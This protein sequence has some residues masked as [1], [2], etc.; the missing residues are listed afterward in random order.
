V[1]SRRRS[2][3]Y[4]GALPATFTYNGSYSTNNNTSGA[5]TMSATVSVG[6]EFA[7]RVVALVFIWVSD[8]DASCVV[9][10]VSIG[11]V[12]CTIA[13]QGNT[14]RA[15]TTRVGVC[16]ALARLPT[17]T[18]ATYSVTFS[19]NHAN[20]IRMTTYSIANL[21]S[22]V[23]TDIN[24]DSVAAASGSSP[25]NLVLDVPVKAA[26]IILAEAA[27]L[28]SPSSGSQSWGGDLT[29]EES[30]NVT[31]FYYSNAAAAFPLSP[32]NAS[33]NCNQTANGAD[34]VGVSAAFW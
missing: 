28:R 18:T 27:H 5:T 17:G 31:N 7:D 9:N 3:K 34:G 20:Q 21:R 6:S 33:I 15:L 24:S 19:S 26:G 32:A 25:S 10:S 30:F 2:I 22:L 23:P 16:I 8:A 13:A 1:S 29:V 14:A 4:D 12:A 11:G